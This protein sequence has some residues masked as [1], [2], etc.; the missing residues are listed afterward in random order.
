MDP[1]FF[2]EEKD[3]DEI[4]YGEQDLLEIEEQKKKREQSFREKKE[5][6]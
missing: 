5:D 4:E 6:S 2:L 1:G 3:H